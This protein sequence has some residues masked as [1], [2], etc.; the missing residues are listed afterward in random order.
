MSNIP[1][2]PFE[3]VSKLP[4]E[5]R[6][7]WAVQ[8]GFITLPIWVFVFVTVAFAVASQADAQQVRC[9]PDK[10]LTAATCAKCH[11][12][13]VAVWK[14]T[15]HAQTFEQLTRN[16]AAKD[17]CS[18]L[19]LRSVKRSDTCIKCHFTQKMVNDKIKAVS[20]VSCESCH[21]AAAD[22]VDGH[23]DYGGPNETKESE[24]P[25]HA[26]E[27]LSESAEYGMRNTRDLYAIASS[28]LNCHT[29][30]DESLVN[31]GG[32][33]AGSA[34][35]ELVRWSQGKVRH[36]FLR[37]GTTN[38]VSSPERLRVM[39]VVGLVADLEFSTRAVATAT[40]NSSYGQAVA[41]RAASVATRLNK[42]QQELSDPNLQLALSAFAQAELRTNNRESLEQIADQIKTA[43]SK[44]AAAAND[45]ID[46]SAVDSYLPDP[47]TYK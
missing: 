23:C 22:W 4:H 24:S 3:T 47:S 21:G 46:L 42:L 17:I 6:E 14:Q 37:N 28:C 18:K 27:R 40:E 45:G 20:G 43:G 35:F 26:A 11:A 5:V 39:F 2:H 30:P 16:P 1:I 34:D 36:N 8:S 7:T 13:E 41:K 33:N 25:E 32:H 15:P 44:F 12:S 10:V 9:D 31:V 19:G 38:A 29:V